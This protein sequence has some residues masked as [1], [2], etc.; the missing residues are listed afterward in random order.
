MAIGQLEEQSSISVHYTEPDGHL[1]VAEAVGRLV[2]NLN[3]INRPTVVVCVGT[4]RSTGDALGPLVGTMLLKTPT[5]RFPVY[6]TLEQPIH[7]LNLADQLD[8]IRQRHFN[9]FIIAVDACLGRQNRIGYINVKQGAV[10]PG[11]ALNKTLPAVGDIHISG[12]VN[13][14][15]FL[16]HLVLQNTRL[17]LVFSMAEIIARGLSCF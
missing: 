15:G 9:P 12:V 14:A 5:V 11:T 4:D 6:G 13:V 3:R 17:G 10:L 8:F 16:E 2:K 1:L 7:A